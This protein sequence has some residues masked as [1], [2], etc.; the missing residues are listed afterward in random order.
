MWKGNSCG[1]FSQIHVNDSEWIVPDGQIIIWFKSA[2]ARKENGWETLINAFYENVKKSDMPAGHQEP[3]F[4]AHCHIGESAPHADE[5]PSRPGGGRLLCGLGTADWPAV[6]QAAATWPGTVAAYGV[7]PWRAAETAAGMRW[8][9]DLEAFL[10]TDARAWAGEIGLDG[11]RT[12]DADEAVQEKAFRLQ[13]RLAARLDRSVN[14]HGVTAWDALVRLLDAEYG[15]AAGEK[16]FIVHSFSGPFQYINPLADRG[17]YFSVGPLAWRRGSRVQT[18]RAKRLPLDRLL[19]ESD[20]FLVPGVDA[21]ADLQKTVAWL[22]GARSMDRAEL[23]G[24]IQENA[25]RL[26]GYGNG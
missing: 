18:E 10:T 11:A 16:T 5:Q 8:L 26:F 24:I 1:L 25:G 3:L 4:D 19:L 13:L 23:A 20:A 12:R 17:A 15:T 22:A 21:I 9:A 14:L 7:H 6:R 2:T